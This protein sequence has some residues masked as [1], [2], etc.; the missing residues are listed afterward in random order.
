MEQTH[1]SPMEKVRIFAYRETIEKYLPCVL[2][3][4]SKYTNSKRLAEIIAL[5]VFIC[6]YQLAKILDG[7][8]TM[9]I[10]IDNLVGVIGE[11]LTKK[12]GTP[13]NGQPLFKWDDDFHYARRLAEMDMEECYEELQKNADFT[14]RCL[15]RS[16]LEQITESAI[17]NLMQINQPKEK[18]HQHFEVEKR[19]IL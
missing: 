13:C 2:V 12:T 10:I 6:S 11:D 19:L 18:K 1:P 5:Y 4:C 17:E 9:A 8:N 15:D 3:K 7:I 14:S 16:Q